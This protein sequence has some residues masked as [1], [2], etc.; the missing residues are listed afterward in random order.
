[1]CWESDYPHS[2][3]SWPRGPEVL[4]ELLQKV[5]DE[6][7]DKM[8]H[9]NAMRHFSFDPFSTRPRESCT[10]VALRA[11]VPD[12]DVV[13]RVGRRPDESD[14]EYFVKNVRVPSALMPKG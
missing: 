5:D 3:S 6:T 10:A 14:R 4:E 2:D 9:R 8:T 12:V 11:E 1:M 13:A 7:S